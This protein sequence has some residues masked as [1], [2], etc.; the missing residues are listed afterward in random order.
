MASACAGVTTSQPMSLVGAWPTRME[1]NVVPLGPAGATLAPG[2]RYAGG[3]SLHGAGLHGLSDLKLAK[4]GVGAWAV[5]DFG[6]LIHFNIRLDARGRLVGADTATRRPLAGLD[7]DLQGAKGDAD[8]EGL[9]LL[10][11]GRLLVSFERDDRIWSYGMDGATT[12]TALRHPDIDFPGNKGMEGLSAAPDRDGQAAW[13]VLGETGG[14]WTC[15][16]G[17]CRALPYAPARIED[18]Y[19]FTSADRDPAGGWF[20]VERYYRPPLTIRARVR[21][22]APDGALGP[23]LITL[24]PPASVDN[25]EGIAVRATPAGARLYLLSDDNDFFLQQTLLL[26]FDI[27]R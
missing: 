7:G 22:M 26:A 23:P 5:S 24:R 27:V 3:L 25:F 6:A 19:L 2:V 12:P 11:D 1:A 20:I 18:G 13:L 4:D 8:A 21:H 15:T 10:D 14:A 9:A 16:V 17:A